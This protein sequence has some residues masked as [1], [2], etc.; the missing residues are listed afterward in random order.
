MGLFFVTQ[1]IENHKAITE[2]ENKRKK[3]KRNLEKKKQF[4]TK[5]K[6]IMEDGE[7]ERIHDFF[8]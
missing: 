4:V 8:I 1:D 7:K 6:G 3:H 5:L 2:Y